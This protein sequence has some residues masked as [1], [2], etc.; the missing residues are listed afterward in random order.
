MEGLG[1]GGGGVPLIVLAKSS[2]FYLANARF[3]NAFSSI[4]QSLSDEL[5]LPTGLVKRKLP[6]C[7]WKSGGAIR[8]GLV[9]AR[10]PPQVLHFLLEG[11]GFSHAQVC[12]FKFVEWIVDEL[13][14]CSVL[15]LIDQRRL[16]ECI[17]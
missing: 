15:E 17:G 9:P 3:A 6:Y 13:N 2:K 12:L 7:K 5:G 4:H 8:E 16:Y 11:K 1:D 14:H 10:R